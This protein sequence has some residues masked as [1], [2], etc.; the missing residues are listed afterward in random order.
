MSNS[1]PEGKSSLPVGKL[2]I[3]SGPSGS[4][5]STVIAQALA[6]PSLPVRLAISATT[7]PPRPKEIDGQHYHF[8]TPE[9]FENGIRAG[10]FLEWADVYGHRYGTLKSEV[11]PFL[12]KGQSVL[13]EVDVQGGM[14]ISKVHP[15]AVLVFIQTSSL[16]EY[17]KRLRSRRTDNE[18]SM[19]KRLASAR[20]ELQTGA[21]HYQHH[22]VNDDLNQAV[23]KLKEIMHSQIGA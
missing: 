23:A 19:Q 4:G 3:L 11:E 21:K 10:K 16:E 17:E 5:K 8:W 7:R 22:I 1:A 2:F 9:Q 15:E 14:Q 18:A 12:Q 13:L 6:D 20:Q